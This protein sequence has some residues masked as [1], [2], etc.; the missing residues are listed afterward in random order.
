MSQDLCF[1]GVDVSLASLEVAFRPQGHTERFPNDDRGIDALV[2]RCQ[3]LAPERIVLE[4]TGGLEVPL[5]VALSDAGLP[6]AV[7]N[8]KRVRAFADAQGQRAK[9]DPLDAE[10]LALFAERIRPEVRPPKQE[11]TRHLGEILTRRRQL[12]QMRVAEENRLCRV[13]DAGVRANVQAHIDWLR[14]QE[15]HLQKELRAY[16]ESN[17]LWKERDQLLQ[18]VPGVGPVVSQTLLA[19]LPELGRL[20]RRQIASLVGLAPYNRDSG[21][22]RGKK[23]ISGGRG[24]VRS[25]LYMGVLSAVRYNPPLS[26]CYRRLRDRGKEAKVA[27]VA[28]A[29]KLLTILNALVRSGRAWEP[30]PA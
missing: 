29:R 25:A 18:G 28:C 24:E 22:K 19:G 15:D 9:T 3:S 20:N 16:I 12:V 30:G 17:A 4:A 27:L 26:E 6:V 5:A 2:R 23:W 7:L 21:K 10:L 1:V 11:H 13:A 14:G 8:P